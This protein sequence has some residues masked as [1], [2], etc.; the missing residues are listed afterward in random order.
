M[1][2][3]LTK[4]EKKQL[5]IFVAAAFGLPLLMGVL[6]GINFYRGADVS[7]FPNA[8][9]FYP[10]AG[11]M[12]AVLLT[13]KPQER[14]P[15]KFYAGFLALTGVLAALCVV[16]V[17]M[18]QTNLV[19]AVNLVIIMGSLVCWLLLLLEKKEVRRKYG[20]GWGRDAQGI[21]PWLWILLFFVLYFLRIFLSYLAEGMPGEFFTLFTNPYLWL[22][23]VLLPLNFFLVYAAF[24]GEEY[25]WRGFFQPLLQKRYGKRLGLL[26]LGVCWGLWHLPINVFYYSPQTWLQSVLAQQTTCI[27]LGIFFGLVM[28]KTK[29]IWVPV[30]M[31]FFNNN[32]IAVMA[33]SADVISGQV[34]AWGDLL[35][36]LLLNGV[37]FASFILA[38]D[39]RKDTTE[40]ES[41]AA[42]QETAEVI[43]E[44]RMTGE[45]SEVV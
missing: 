40:F 14:V 44:M 9:M 27:G 32:L 22:N 30:L 26:I 6:M 39:F 2:K 16:S 5:W 31:H 11:V 17:L 10:A 28:M 41:W 1:E 24:F 36:L 3:R 29:N 21:R 43:G 18:P 33:G 35:L 25:G 38:K 7:V 13:R 4:R 12:L 20:L 8:Q 37:L 45:E 19:G 42:G 34:I 15:V 23:L